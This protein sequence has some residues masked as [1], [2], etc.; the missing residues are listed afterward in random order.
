[1]LTHYRS[2]TRSC[3]NTNH[4]NHQTDGRR[5]NRFYPKYKSGDNYDV[6]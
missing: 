2:E 4:E 3:P 1:M 5:T 6:L